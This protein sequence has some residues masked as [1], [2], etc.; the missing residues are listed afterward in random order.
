MID[1]LTKY[2]IMLASLD[3]TDRGFNGSLRSKIWS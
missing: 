2:L 1:F 3:E